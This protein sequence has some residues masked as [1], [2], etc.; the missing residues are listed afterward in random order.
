MKKVYT[1][2][3]FLSFT[4]FAFSQSNNDTINDNTPKL[5]SIEKKNSDLKVKTTTDKKTLKPELKMYSLNQVNS[6]SKKKDSIMLSKPEL[7]PTG[8]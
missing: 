1:L 4:F 6:N 2:I 7:T 8:F 5:I 3:F